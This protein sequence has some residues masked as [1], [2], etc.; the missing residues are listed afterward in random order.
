MEPSGEEIHDGKVAS[1]DEEIADPNEYW[2]LLLQE[3]W[4]EDR[5][6][7]DAKFYENERDGEDKCE[8]QRNYH[9]RAVPLEPQLRCCSMRLGKTYW[10]AFVVSVTEED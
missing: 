9:V 8:Y 10:K 6:R 3:E 2:D 5:F 1:R 4:S 7:G